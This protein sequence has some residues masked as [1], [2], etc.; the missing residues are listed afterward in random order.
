MSYVD[1][2]NREPQN[3]QSQFKV[4]M[5]PFFGEIISRDEV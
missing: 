1:M 2:Q 5:G 4:H 3:V